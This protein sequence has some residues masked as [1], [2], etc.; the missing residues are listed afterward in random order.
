[1]GG[2]IGLHLLTL[3]SVPLVDEDQIKR[4]EQIITV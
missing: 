4:L 3:S 1:M 2:G